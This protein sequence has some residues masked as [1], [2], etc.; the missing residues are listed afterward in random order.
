MGDVPLALR[1][2]GTLGHT[3]ATRRNLLHVAASD[4][5]TTLV[6]A[7]LYITTWKMDPLALLSGFTYV[8][9]EDRKVI[10]GIVLQK[11]K[12]LYSLVS[13]YVHLV[14]DVYVRV[15]GTTAPPLGQ[16]PP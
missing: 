11:L 4:V 8:Q 6:I 5:N 15:G 7:L 3:A 13:M 1:S 10:Q 12:L 2:C 14:V 16:L 9:G